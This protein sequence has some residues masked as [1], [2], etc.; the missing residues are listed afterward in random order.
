MIF[1]SPFLGNSASAD[2]SKSLEELIYGESAELA[3]PTR[4]VHTKMCQA[5]HLAQEKLHFGRQIGK[6]FDFSAVEMQK[7]T[8]ETIIELLLHE[9]GHTL[10]LSHNFRSSQIWDKNQVHDQ[11]LTEKEGLTGSVMDYNPM[12]IATDRTK[13]GNYQS[14]V[15][16]PYDKWAI[17]YSYKPSL[18]DANAEKQRVEKLLNR[19]TDPL[20]TFGND[21]DAH[22]SPS[23]GIDPTIN[24]W[25][26][27][28]DAIGYG[29]DR[30]QLCKETM[31]E[32]GN[33]LT[34]DGK[35]YQELLFGHNSLMWNYY[36]SLNVIVRYIGGVKIDRSMKGQSTT[37]KPFTPVS[38]TEQKRA[39][40]A[41]TEHGFSPKAFTA[42]SGLYNYLQRQRRGW[43]HWG[44]TEDPKILER[45]GAYQ[46]SLLSHVLHPTVLKRMSNARFYGNGY[47]VADMLSDL[48]DGIFDADLKGNVNPP[49]QNLQI[50]YVE[51]LIGGLSKGDHNSISKSAMLYELQAIQKML[52][53]NKGKQLETKAHRAHIQYLIDK[54]LED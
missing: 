25:D 49:R 53:S 37:A 8:D 31:Q 23:V 42:P 10:G 35:S 28:S 38:V 40:K 50:T 24:T 18:A 21:A 39:M 22:R 36:R 4:H 52:K 14:V 29:L 17:E 30:I 7:M 20:L 12:N 5:N 44:S 47:A 33:K 2:A 48:T 16:G 1:D 43:D 41:L 15:P 3:Q 9:V 19:S 11:S 13:Q 32:I 54:A 6:A 46:R 45:I 34:T 26:M 27:S 51:G